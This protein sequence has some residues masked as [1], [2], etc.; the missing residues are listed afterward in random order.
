MSSSLKSR[1][2]EWNLKGPRS[3][4]A[5]LCYLREIWGKPE[6]FY[7]ATKCTHSVIRMAEGQRR[8]DWV[9]SEQLE[10]KGRALQLCR[11]ED[12]NAK[13]DQHPE[14]IRCCLLI[15]LQRRAA[16][17]QGSQDRIMRISTSEKVKTSMLLQKI[18]KSRPMFAQI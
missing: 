9:G 6:M 1:F 10:R 15:M 16:S 2:D 3:E 14:N 12:E 18:L 17:A 5:D 13:S 8:K 11:P 4:E 7:P